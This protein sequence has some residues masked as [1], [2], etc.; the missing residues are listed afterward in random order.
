MLKDSLIGS[1][2]LN[3]NSDL[4]KYKYSGYGIGF[5]ASGRFSLSD[6]SGFGKYKKIFGAYMNSSAHI[7][8]R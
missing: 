2:K 5:D 6:G 8:N 1:V 7:D 4:D 3:K